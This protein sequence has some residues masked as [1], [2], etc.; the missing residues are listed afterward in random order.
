V[1]GKVT[2]RSFPMGLHKNMAVASCLADPVM[3][4]AV[5]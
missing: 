3:T 2:R 5:L 1:L 4:E